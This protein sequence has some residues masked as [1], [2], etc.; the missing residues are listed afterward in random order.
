MAT[1]QDHQTTHLD[2]EVYAKS[3]AHEFNDPERTLGSLSLIE[4]DTEAFLQGI[5][6]R[7]SPTAS[8]MVFD[9]DRT[10]GMITPTRHRIQKYLTEG[11]FVGPMILDG[12]VAPLGITVY[13]TVPDQDDNI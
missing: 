9:S 1:E 4:I 3:I 11:G 2:P 7:F 10:I 13:R 5:E 12:S 6:G 8:V